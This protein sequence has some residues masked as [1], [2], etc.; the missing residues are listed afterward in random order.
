MRRC[1]ARPGPVGQAPGRAREPRRRR[2]A[3]IVGPPGSEILH[4][5]EVHPVPD[6][7]GN[8]TDGHKFPRSLWETLLTRR[9]S[10]ERAV[11]SLTVAS[12]CR[13]GPGMAAWFA[14]TAPHDPPGDWAGGSMVAGTLARRLSVLAVIEIGRKTSHAL[15]QRSELARRPFV[16]RGPAPYGPRTAPR[17]GDRR[18]GNGATPVRGHVRVFRDVE[19]RLSRFRPNGSVR[20]RRQVHRRRRPLRAGRVDRPNTGGPQVSHGAGGS[21]LRQKIARL[22]QWIAAAED[23][24]SADK[25]VRRRG[26]SATKWR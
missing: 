21:L 23:S 3:R 15:R 1:R 10:A 4:G 8:V 7:H 5:D 20:R 18:T 2:N 9:R 16:D 13:S 25:C 24:A 11:I 12:C 22:A 14:G 17:H 19:D 26:K 6:P